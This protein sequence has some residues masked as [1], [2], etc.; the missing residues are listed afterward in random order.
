MKNSN[1]IF[2]VII[3]VIGAVLALTMGLQVGT[4]D[5]RTL[6]IWFA[7]GG[8]GLYLLRGYHYSW[9]L[10]LLV[11]FLG[12]SMRP[13]GFEISSS[14]I[15]FLF[16]IGL[17]VVTLFRP[18]M[19]GGRVLL[20]SGITLI[21][22]ICFVWI[23]YGGLH[24]LFNHFSPVYPGQWALRNAITRYFIAFSGPCLLLWFTLFPKGIDLGKNWLK[25]V[26]YCMAFALGVNV[27]V[28]L[29]LM[30]GFGLEMSGDRG[31][32]YAQEGLIY[33]PMINLIPGVEVLRGLGPLSAGLSYALLTHARWMRKQTIFTRLAVYATFGLGLFGSAF[34][35]GRAALLL[36]I[37]FIMILS[38]LRRKFFHISLGIGLAV[39]L[40]IFANLSSH[41][42]KYNAPFA[43][44]RSL[45]HLLIDRGGAASSSIDSSTS[46]R[47]ELFERGIKEWSED[48]R[49]FWTGR[50]T[51][52]FDVGDSNIQKT[53][54][55]FEAGIESA[56]RRGATHNMI[57]DVLIQ[58][59]LIGIIL[60]LA[61][62]LAIIRFLVKV[63]GKVRGD[64]DLEVFCNFGL[65]YYVGMLVYK[66]VGGSFYSVF[67]L[68]FI[69]IIVIAV[70]SKALLETSKARTPKPVTRRV[71]G[72]R[73]PQTV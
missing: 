25:V 71:I 17:A 45:Q 49:I 10:I 56:L 46:W 15:S 23:A 39:G 61:L 32:F 66:S 65:I 31:Q 58:Y 64:L 16:G 8:V 60:Y 14:H 35:G 37:L 27:L 36:A 40:F 43:L 42:V 22:V 53:M 6:L 26:F 21:Q 57:T 69:V 47:S 19:G 30:F 28:R 41:W 51:M 5:Y 72:S 59:G 44:S 52:V 4:Q 12:F 73:L 48:T 68:W 24:F 38:V 33:I 34:S 20:G 11:S 7:I 54:G 50:A 62:I 9:Q 70:R 55:G 2:Q 67:E 1:A 3:V 29:V 18:T 63:R 13:L